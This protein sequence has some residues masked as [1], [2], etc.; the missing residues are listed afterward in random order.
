[1][2]SCK[3]TAILLALAL[4]CA[5]LPV[6]AA[7]EELPARRLELY[8]QGS[9]DIETSDVWA[10]MPGKDGRG[11]LFERCDYGFVCV[12]EVSEDTEEVGFIVRTN[13]SKPGGS[14]WGEAT[15][16]FADDRFAVLTGNVTKIYLK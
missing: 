14:S 5:Y 12:I 7:A 3:F 2:R 6:S 16:D 8:W 9:A 13:C 1:M 15:K 10:W 11:Y 4:I